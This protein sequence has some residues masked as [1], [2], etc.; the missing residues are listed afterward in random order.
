[1]LDTIN[2]YFFLR[3]DQAGELLRVPLE[4][5]MQNILYCN[6]I[7]E[8]I[9]SESAILSFCMDTL[10]LKGPLPAG[11]VGKLLSEAASIPNLSHKLREKFGGLK[12]F[13]ERYPEIFVFSND[14]PFNPHVLLR[15]TLSQE[16]LDLIYRGVFPYQLI[17][18]TGT[19][20]ISAV[21]GVSQPGAA[22]PS[23]NGLPGNPPQTATASLPTT[24][25]SMPINPVLNIP[26]S[27]T[28]TIPTT[29]GLGNTSGIRALVSFFF[30][31]SLFLRF[32]YL[33]R[34]F[35]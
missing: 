15:N 4:K 31:F 14:H 32:I 29:H 3:P 5:L 9:I 24:I 6:F 17:A 8:S 27:L 21:P 20:S 26:T 7:V 10:V 23:M 19:P 22:S 35:L 30:F 34:Y 18:K 16:N 33:S 11:E 12:K 28:S 1:M 25:N 2:S 13:L